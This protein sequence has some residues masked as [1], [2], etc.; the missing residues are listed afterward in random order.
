MS[1]PSHVL[2]ATELDFEYR[3]GG[4]VLKKVTLTAAANCD[5]PLSIAARASVS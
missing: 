1:D 2:Q 3:V 4:P 5:T